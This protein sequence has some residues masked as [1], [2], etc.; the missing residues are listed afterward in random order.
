VVSQILGLASGSAFPTGITTNTFVVTDTS[1]NTNTCSFTVTVSDNEKPVLTCP[2][3]I[4]TNAPGVCASNV[5]VT[6]SA[7]AT[8]NC[9][10]AN[11]TLTPPSGTLFDVGTNVVTAVAYDS[12]GNTNLCTFNVVVLPGST[13]SPVLGISHASSDVVLSWPD[14]F[15]C[16]QLQ[17]AT[18]LSGV[19][20]FHPGPF[21]PSGG[22]IYATNAIDSTNRF[23]RLIR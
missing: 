15:T 10:V 6:Y 19:W 4:V 17:Q 13:S 9:A 16:F 18:D 11:V 14:V 3:E 5:V 8:D 22:S 12:S 21:V 1:G 7:G 20:S 2:S 23:F